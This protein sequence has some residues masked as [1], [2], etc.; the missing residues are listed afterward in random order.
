MQRFPILCPT[1][2][3]LVIGTGKLKKAIRANH[4]DVELEFSNGA[5]ILFA[6]TRDDKERHTSSWKPVKDTNVKCRAIK[7]GEGDQAGWEIEF[8]GKAPKEVTVRAHVNR[9]QEM[10]QISEDTY[11]C[12]F[13]TYGGSSEESGAGS[14][15]KSGD[16][17]QEESSDSNPAEDADTE[18]V[19][20]DQQ[21]T[22]E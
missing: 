20:G 17:Q 14:S 12:S 16:K 13:T 3:G 10:T 8:E 11:K 15:S 2:V 7:T 22:K 18:S 9:N 6:W 21:E 1:Y 4:G 19:E 5:K